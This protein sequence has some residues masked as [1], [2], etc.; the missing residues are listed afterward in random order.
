MIILRAFITT[1]SLNFHFLLHIF[2]QLPCDLRENSANPLNVLLKRLSYVFVG[3]TARFDDNFSPFNF[4][5][6]AVLPISENCSLV[7]ILLISG[8]CTCYNKEGARLNDFI[9]SFPP[10][11]AGEAL[12]LITCCCYILFT[13]C[14]SSGCLNCHRT[15]EDSRCRWVQTKQKAYLSGIYHNTTRLQLVD[16]V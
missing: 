14:M 6:I 12:G 11:N 1:L 16:D 5:S 15:H 13:Q 10:R 9:K 7:L 3:R 8:I 2:I 4:F